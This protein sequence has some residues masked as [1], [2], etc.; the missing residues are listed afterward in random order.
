MTGSSDE[1]G[2]FCRFFGGCTERLE[3][4]GMERGGGVGRRK[5]EDGALGVR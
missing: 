4:E 3:R 1:V 2:G 5:G